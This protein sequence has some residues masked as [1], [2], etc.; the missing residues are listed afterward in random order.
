[1]KVPIWL[2]FLLPTSLAWLG[3]LF[4]AADKDW[5]GALTLLAASFLTM[6][7]VIAAVPGGPIRGEVRIPLPVRP[8]RRTRHEKRMD[9]L[10]ARLEEVEAEMDRQ[11]EGHPDREAL[12]ELARI[13]RARIEWEREDMRQRRFVAV[14]KKA[15]KTLDGEK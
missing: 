2:F 1:M 12:G 9:E 6:T 11:P 14:T 8:R 10:S 15:N 5:P 3:F 13:I 4:V 7:L